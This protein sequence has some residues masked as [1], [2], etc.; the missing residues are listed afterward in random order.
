MPT[1]DV[2]SNIIE[3]NQ[4]NFENEIKS[5]NKLNFVYCFAIWC[6]PCE[7]VWPAFQELAIEYKKSV[8]FCRINVDESPRLVETNGVT[9]VPIVLIIKDC[10]IMERIIGVK[11]KEEYALQIKKYLDEIISVDPTNGKRCI[12]FNDSWKKE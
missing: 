12:D 9:A 6:K 1:E 11:K 3:L 5:S 8:K 2:P 7:M 4:E 10:K